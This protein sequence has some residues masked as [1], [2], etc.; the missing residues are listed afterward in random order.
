MSTVTESV[1]FA[2]G[3]VVKTLKGGRYMLGLS[4]TGLGTV[5]LQRVLGDG[6]TFA[7]IPDINGTALLF[8]TQSWRVADLAPGTYQIVIASAT[9]VKLIATSVPS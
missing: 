5:S 4:A 1:T 3:D 9:A 2:T 8:S 7:T 6:A